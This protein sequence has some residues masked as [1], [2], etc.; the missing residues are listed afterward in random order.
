MLSFGLTVAGIGMGIVFTELI[1]LVGVIYVLSIF[2]GRINGS[3]PHKT[4]KPDRVQEEFVSREADA[5]SDEENVLVVIAAALACFGRNGT[6]IAKITRIKGASASA[7]SNAGRLDT[8]D[9][10]QL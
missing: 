5:A 3:K 8:M 4:I 10:R 2:A 1:L 6:R 9:L 7:W